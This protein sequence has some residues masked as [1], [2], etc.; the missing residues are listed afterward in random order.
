LG[1]FNFVFFKVWKNEVFGAF[2][3]RISVT[4]ASSKEKGV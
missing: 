2:H 1:N 3:G 4:A